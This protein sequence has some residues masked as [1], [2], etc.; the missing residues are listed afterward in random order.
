MAARQAHQELHTHCLRRGNKGHLPTEEAGATARSSLH[1]SLL[2]KGA[3]TVARSSANRALGVEA[4]E[5][6]VLI[7]VQEATVVVILMIAEAPFY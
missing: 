6:V 2:A 5:V 7:V 3:S 1:R 4:V